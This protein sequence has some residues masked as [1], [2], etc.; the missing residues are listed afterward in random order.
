ML[1]IL[2]PECNRELKIPEQYLGEWGTCKHCGKR[3]Q[4][5]ASPLTF[6]KETYEELDE[7]AIDSSVDNQ[8]TVPPIKCRSKEM[9]DDDKLKW[10]TKHTKERNWN[11]ICA[12]NQ[13][14]VDSFGTKKELRALPEFLE[15]EEVVFAFTSGIM[16]QTKTSNVFDWGLNTWL[17]V[18]TSERFL[19]LDAAML[20][21]SV[22][23]QSVRMNHVQAV[24]ASQGWLLGKIQIDLG[25]RIITIDNCAK[26]TVRI[27]AKLANNWIKQIE[28]RKESLASSDVVT[29]KSQPLDE[30]EK[31]AAL[32]SK[33]VLT[34]DEFKQAKAKVLDS[35]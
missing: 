21:R 31:L 25:S 28:K 22:D 34:E 19:F 24:S 7:S 20:T 4:V 26:S 27:M 29:T 16:K 12:M 14:E 15:D 9:I 3:I 23:T 11:A 33:G 6:S 18:L 32:Y 17:V 1:T 8:V 2:C 30:L 10:Y 35:L 5:Q 13:V